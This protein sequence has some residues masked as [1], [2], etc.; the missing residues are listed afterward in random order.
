MSSRF[1][2]HVHSVFTNSLNVKVGEKLINLNADEE[3]LSSYGISVPEAS[4]HPV[5]LGCKADDLVTYKDQRLLFYG[6]LHETIIAL[7]SLDF[8][9]L[10][11]PKGPAT[12]ISY[13]PVLEKLNMLK[14]EKNVGLPLNPKMKK[15]VRFMETSE[16]NDLAAI[17][18][19]IRFLVGRGKG[20]TP[21]GDDFLMGFTMVL[22]SV[23]KGKLWTQQLNRLIDH[24]STDISIAYYKALF[25]GY[26]SLP[27]VE[28]LRSIHE[29]NLHDMD[30]SIQ[31]IIKLG[32]T[33]GYDTLYGIYTGGLW[34]KNQIIKGDHYGY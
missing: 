6:R 8:V 5:I 9:D 34:V 24:Q 27:F 2:G 11:I 26:V 15:M 17:E 12:H 1:T 30:L 13:L 16:L 3:Q 31:K 29:E 7:P 23:E 22:M 25:E 20:L 4:L 14:F 10:R 21:S 33:S 28:L 32:H 18:E 19:V